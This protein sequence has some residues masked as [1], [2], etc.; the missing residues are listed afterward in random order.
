MLLIN[1]HNNDENESMERFRRSQ[2]VI[3]IMVEIK[4]MGKN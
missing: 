1:F 4:F 2:G 3:S